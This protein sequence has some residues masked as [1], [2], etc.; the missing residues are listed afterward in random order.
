V[1]DNA[2]EWYVQ[3]PYDMCK[4]EKMKV[5]KLERKRKHGELKDKWPGN[6]TYTPI[7]M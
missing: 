5:G 4:N 2:V 1:Y 6:G 3:Q 7:A